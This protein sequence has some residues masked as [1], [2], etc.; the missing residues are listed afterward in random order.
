MFRTGFK[1]FIIFMVFLFPTLLKS[2]PA[3]HDSIDNQMPVVEVVF[4][5]DLSG[6][7]NGLIDNV[8]EQ[9]WSVVNMIATASPKENCESV[10]SGFPALVLED[11]IIM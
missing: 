3:N 8:R 4:C 1:G 10:W 6:S 2:M 5:L 11:K 9:V 7:T